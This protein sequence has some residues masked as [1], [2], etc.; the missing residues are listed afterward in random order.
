M[1]SFHEQALVPLHRLTGLADFRTHVLQTD[2]LLRDTQ[3]D[4]PAK[5]SR[6]GTEISHDQ[7]VSLRVIWS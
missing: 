2:Q 3:C 7:E 1:K 5:E 4:L 6:E